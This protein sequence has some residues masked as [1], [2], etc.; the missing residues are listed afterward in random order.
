MQKKEICQNV[1]E[2]DK[3][4]TT[5]DKHANT[6]VEAKMYAKPGNPL[7][8]VES[9]QRFISK[10][11]SDENLWQRTLDSHVDEEDVWFYNRLVSKNTL[12]NL[13]KKISSSAKLSQIYTNNSLN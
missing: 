8:P 9:F 11:S 7:C 5:K 6:V 12:G 2:A 10:L 13:R 1:G 3:N 4:H